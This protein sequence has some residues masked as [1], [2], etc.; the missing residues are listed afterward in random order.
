MALGVRHAYINDRMH[1]I[2][3]TGTSSR[4]RAIG[5]ANRWDTMV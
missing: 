4:V 1:A 3:R 2:G 5:I